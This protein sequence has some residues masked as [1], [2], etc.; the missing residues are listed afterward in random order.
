MAKINLSHKMT[1][2]FIEILRNLLFSDEKTRNKY[3]K[4]KAGSRKEDCFNVQRILGSLTIFF[5]PLL[6]PPKKID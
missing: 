4:P 5:A 3:S 6:Y 1:H 2:W